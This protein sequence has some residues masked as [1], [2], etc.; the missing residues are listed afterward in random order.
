MTAVAA[1]QPVRNEL[2]APS[3]T[4]PQVRPGLALWP[5]R[6]LRTHVSRRHVAALGGRRRA[7][8]DFFRTREK[9]WP[10]HASSSC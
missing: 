1:V 2:G 5:E 10:A 7:H 3:L 8:E 9:P 6:T 4:D